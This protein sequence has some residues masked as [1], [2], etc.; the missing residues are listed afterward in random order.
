MTSSTARL[1]FIALFAAL[2]SLAC[3]AAVRD[4]AAGALSLGVLA[5][6]VSAV[7]PLGRLVV[8]NASRLIPGFGA[9]LAVLLA[10]AAWLG[11]RPDECEKPRG[12]LFA[13]SFALAGE[14]LLIEDQR[15]LGVVL[16]ALAA[17]FILRQSPRSGAPHVDDGGGRERFRFQF[18]DLG[19]LSAISLLAVF[20]RFYALNRVVDYFEGELSPYLAAATDLRGML[21]ANVGGFGGPWAPLGYF[22]YLPV[23]VMTQL[24]GTTVLAVRLAS[25]VVSVLTVPLLHGFLRRIAGRE[26]AV[27]G[28]LFVALD[29]LQ[30]GWGRSDIHPHGSTVWPAILLCWAMVDA[31][32]TGLWRYFFSVALLMGLS[33]HQYPSGQVAVGIPI[34]FLAWNLTFRSNDHF[35]GVRAVGAVATGLALW[36]FGFPLQYLLAYGRWHTYD[37][38]TQYGIRTSWAG[39]E[40][41]DRWSMLSS[42]AARALANFDDLIAGLFIKVPYL[43]HQEFIPDY[44]EVPLRT[45]F[46]IAAAAAFVVTVLAIRRPRDSRTVILVL[47]AFCGLLPSALSDHG[48]AKRAAIAYVAVYALAAV[49]LA[50]VHRTLVARSPRRS[51]TP[52]I[53]AEIAAM[54]LVTM[55]STYQWFSGAH[56]AYGEPREIAIAKRIRERLEPG[57]IVIADFAHHYQR[58]MFTFLLI[59]ALGDPKTFPVAW[60]VAEG[61]PIT[62]EDAA[63]SPEKTITALNRTIWYKWTRLGYQLPGLQAAPRWSRV[64]FLFESAPHDANSQ[65]VPQ[66]ASMIRERCPDGGD[67]VFEDPRS[68]YRFD[69]FECRLS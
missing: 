51:P 13:C 8:D 61:S 38:F 5:P 32:E 23:F 68:D 67:E 54:L 60:V 15:S 47:W 69:I 33:S 45:V 1:A 34:A 46:W 9:G 36:L 18:A 11:G 30:I 66:H 16:Y 29:P 64:L 43:F 14:V 26:A 55:A 50:S 56:Y 49:G 44:P 12:F 27:I 37:V 17:F 25:A 42:V 52:L 53:T 62:F 10:L 3:V 58:G 4:D 39:T 48:Y 59:D 2:V 20:F 21:Y 57:T 28:A 41:L 35:R 22:Y 31:A 63:R 6:L 65:L 24:F 7:M 19:Y 40:A